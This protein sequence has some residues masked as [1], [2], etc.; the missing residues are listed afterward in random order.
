MAEKQA[1]QHIV[2]HNGV[3]QF[4]QGDIVRR[5]DWGFPTTGYDI[6]ARLQQL[7]DQKALQEVPDSIPTKDTEPSVDP[8]RSENPP[9]LPQEGMPSKTTPVK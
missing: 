4:V 6:D 7:V 2:L 8:L 5:E 1:K 9:T 3:G